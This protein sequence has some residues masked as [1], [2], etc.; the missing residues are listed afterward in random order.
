[1]S[2]SRAATMASPRVGADAARRKATSAVPPSAIGARK[3]RPRSRRRRDVSRVGAGGRRDARS[4]RARIARRGERVLRRGVARRAPER[5]A[6]PRGGARV[7]P[8]RRG[9]ARGGCTRR[10]AAGRR[11]RVDARGEGRRRAPRRAG[12]R[13]AGA[14]RFARRPPARRRARRRT[15]RARSARLDAIAAAVPGA[16][17]DAAS[18]RRAAPGGRG[19]R[20]SAR[21]RCRPSCAREF[22][23]PWHAAAPPERA[24][25]RRRPA[26]WRRADAASPSAVATDH[27]AGGERSRAE[28][29]A[30][31]RRAPRA[32]P[33]ADARDAPRTCVPAAAR[34]S[35]RAARG[36]A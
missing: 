35:S 28:P 27:R 20:A 2:A 7:A 16:R 26:P 3:A 9:H 30:R 5:E 6:S 19:R 21:V 12:R 32:R 25:D 4:P 23:R 1:M 17:G 24:R 8:L 22:A 36:R 15:R 34:D 13:G 10:R 31:A 33:S 29:A 14:A 11:R 18:G